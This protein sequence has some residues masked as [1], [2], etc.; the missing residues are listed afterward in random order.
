MRQKVTLCQTGT[1]PYLECSAQA[2]Q[3][4]CFCRF[5]SLGHPGTLRTPRWSL[6]PSVAAETSMRLHCHL[7]Q[8]SHCDRLPLTVQDCTIDL[9]FATSAL[10]SMRALAYGMVAADVTGKVAIQGG[11]EW[12]CT[13]R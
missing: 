4:T 5:G 9:T 1:A 7:Y 11:L 3:L 12:Q 10:I 13:Y 6:A 2:V 8:H